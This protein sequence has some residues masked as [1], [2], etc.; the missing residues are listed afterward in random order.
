MVNSAFFVPSGEG[1]EAI[2]EKA[3][4]TDPKSFST[5]PERRAQVRSSALSHPAL[6]ALLPVLCL[7]EMY[8]GRL[9][10]RP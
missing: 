8:H 5:D 10:Q 9:E 2:Y 4:S 6:H 7:L 3:S 1:L